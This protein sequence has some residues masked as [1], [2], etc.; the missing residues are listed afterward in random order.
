MFLCYIHFFCKPGILQGQ[1]RSG[2]GDVI[3]DEDEAG[4]GYGGEGN[5]DIG[6]D[7]DDDG[8]CG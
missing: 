3:D 6:G 4:Y 1:V 8:R 7:K 2:D 5:G